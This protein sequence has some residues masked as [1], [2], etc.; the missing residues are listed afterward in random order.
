MTRDE[1]A[2]T[3]RSR[4]FEAVKQSLMGEAPAGAYRELAA[5]LGMSQGALYVAA[6]RLRHRCRVLL[7]EA[8]GRTVESGDDIEDEIRHLFAAVS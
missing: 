8:V 1:A 6:H 3:G 5:E 4:L 7:Y 2:R